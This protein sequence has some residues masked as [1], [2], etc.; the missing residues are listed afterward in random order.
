MPVVWLLAQEV[1]V[2]VDLSTW[3]QFGPFAI[4]FVLM[5]AAIGWLLRD[6]TRTKA[7]YDADVQAH[8]EQLDLE[9]KA[10]RDLYD[11]IIAQQDRMA[12]LLEQTARAL[13]HAVERR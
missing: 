9:R 10:N 6:R 1:A 13:D 5:A 11:R 12:P 3:D 2:P 7:N 8:R 4:C